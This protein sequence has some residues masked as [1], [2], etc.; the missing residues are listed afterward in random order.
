MLQKGE[1]FF[2]RDYNTIQKKTVLKP[3]GIIWDMDNTILQSHI[4]FHRMHKEV[5]D[6]L[7]EKQVLVSGYAS[8][9]TVETLMAMECFPHYEPS[10]GE[11]A[12]QIVRRVEADGMSNASLEPGIVEVLL[13]LASEVHMMVL[14]NNSQVPAEV[15]LARN[16][17]AHFFD[18]VWGRE[19]VPELKPASGGVKHILTQFPW[20]AHWLLIGDACIDARACQGQGV[21]FA[22]YQ[23][24][25][26]EALSSYGPVLMFDRWHADC[27]EK[28]L[29]Y[30]HSCK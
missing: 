25:R 28:I 3:Y 9:T 12:W 5:C 10:W 16:Q 8:L 26:R 29:A 20:V 22:G 1:I 4:D 18:G 11:V 23:G 21:A 13:A 24:S 6:Y 14:T 17:V 27:A 30:F 15:G 7:R 19:C 2:L